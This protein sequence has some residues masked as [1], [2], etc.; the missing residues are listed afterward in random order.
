MGRWG[1]PNFFFR[2]IILVLVFLAGLVPTISAHEKSA[3][4]S[5]RKGFIISLDVGGGGLHLGGGRDLGA[6]LG[7]FKIGGGISERILLLAEDT[8]GIG[9]AGDVPSIEGIF[10]APQFFATDSFYVRPGFGFGF[11]EGDV[12]GGR[13]LSTDLGFAAGF[14]AGYEWRLTK[15][16]AISPEAKF[17][18]LRVEGDNNYSFGVVADL[19]LYF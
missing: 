10:F 2:S 14:A 5:D 19:R 6:F 15:R 9:F 7:G 17:N 4:R 18:Y 3:D 8:T 13:T 11:A 16:F 1:N 12:G